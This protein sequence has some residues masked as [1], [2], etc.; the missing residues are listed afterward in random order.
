M[1]NVRNQI[2]AEIISKND[3]ERITKQQS[4]LTIIDIHK[5]YTNTFK[6]NQT[7]MDKPKHLGFALLE[8]IKLLLYEI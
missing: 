2:K 6:Q 5:S 7:L 4:K 3:G 8:L 1:G